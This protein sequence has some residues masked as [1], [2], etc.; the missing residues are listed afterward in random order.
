MYVVHVREA[1][2]LTAMDGGNAGYAGAITGHAA[3]G[4][5]ICLCKQVSWL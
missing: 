2:G 1:A 4:P 3:E 5:L